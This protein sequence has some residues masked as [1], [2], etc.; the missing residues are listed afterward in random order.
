MGQLAWTKSICLLMMTERSFTPIGG[1]RIYYSC[2]EDINNNQLG[3]SWQPTTT[4]SGEYHL[5]WSS[6]AHCWAAKRLQIP[7][8]YSSSAGA[9]WTGHQHPVRFDWFTSQADIHPFECE[10]CRSDLSGRNQSGML[11]FRNCTLVWT[12]TKL[13]HLSLSTSLRDIIHHEKAS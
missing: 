2:N 4:S 12:S 13:L 1:M 3:A 10:P 7:L 11:Q 6:T 8:N 9:N 5:L